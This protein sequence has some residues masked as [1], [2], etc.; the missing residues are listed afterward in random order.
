MP[1]GVDANKFITKSPSRFEMSSDELALWK[2][3]QVNDLMN[4][5]F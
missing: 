4:Q 3:L 5:I 1:V 2:K